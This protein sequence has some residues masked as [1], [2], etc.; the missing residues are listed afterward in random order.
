MFEKL[1]KYK[2]V[3]KA[4]TMAKLENVDLN[5]P[6]SSMSIEERIKGKQGMQK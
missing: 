5:L 6:S 1:K 2:E 3:L 4:L